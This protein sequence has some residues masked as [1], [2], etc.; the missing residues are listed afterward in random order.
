MLLLGG[1]SLAAA[2][3]PD[4]FL[5][6][7]SGAEA[8]V[9]CAQPSLG[10]SGEPVDPGVKRR[11]ADSGPM[12]S[13]GPQ[14]IST[15]TST[16]EPLL[17]W[18]IRRR[19][20][21]ERRSQG[22]GG[23]A[24]GGDGGGGG[25]GGVGGSGGLPP[26]SRPQASPADLYALIRYRYDEV[27]DMLRHD[28]VTYAEVKDCIEDLVPPPPKYIVQT[29]ESARVSNLHFLVA[30]LPS[31]HPASLPHLSPTLFMTVLPPSF[32]QSK[33]MPEKKPGFCTCLSST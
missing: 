8:S 4:I 19:R 24:A 29:P 33:F 11:A 14:T 13:V 16:P 2:R 10:C 15:T 28:Q 9:I 7:A 21:L 26:I 20:R 27:H 12:H 32:S 3:R 22:G 18:Q 17:R 5:S 30:M 1:P 31:R 25:G 23:A 6:T